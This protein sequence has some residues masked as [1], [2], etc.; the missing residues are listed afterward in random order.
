MAF[1]NT[2]ENLK[3]ERSFHIVV[4]CSAKFFLRRAALQ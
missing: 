2:L 1:G 3:V 4:A